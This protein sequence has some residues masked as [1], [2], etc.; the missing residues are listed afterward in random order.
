MQILA[1]LH[2]RSDK[3]FTQTSLAVV[4]LNHTGVRCN[5]MMMAVKCYKVQRI[6]MSDGQREVSMDKDHEIPTNNRATQTYR[7]RGT[8]ATRGKQKEPARAREREREREDSSIIS[9]P[10]ARFCIHADGT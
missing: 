4:Q 2:I 1:E 3:G 8:K 6:L 5:R 7:K 9:H 10:Y